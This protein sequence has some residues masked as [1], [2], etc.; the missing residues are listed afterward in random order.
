MSPEQHRTF[1]ALLA[2]RRKELRLSQGQLAARLA[3]EYSAQLVNDL[4]SR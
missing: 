1:G 2:A 4:E 3:G